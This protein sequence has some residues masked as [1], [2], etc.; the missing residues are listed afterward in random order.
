LYITESN[1]RDLA[2]KLKLAEDAEEIYEICEST[3]KDQPPSV[4]MSKVELTDW[5]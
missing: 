1:V 4:S 2:G 5:K 3:I